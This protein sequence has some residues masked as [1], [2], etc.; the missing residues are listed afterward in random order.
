MEYVFV[1]LSIFLI[2]TLLLS[3]RKKNKELRAIRQK[4]DQMQQLDAQLEQQ[5]Q[6]LKLAQAVILQESKDRETA[7]AVLCQETLQ[8][9]VLKAH[10]IQAEIWEHINTIHLYAS[11]TEEEDTA[12]AVKERQSEIIRCAEEIVRLIGSLTS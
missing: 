11:L 7:Q 9:T 4:A 2:V 1:A 5:M 3:M 8:N 6:D 10:S 12:P